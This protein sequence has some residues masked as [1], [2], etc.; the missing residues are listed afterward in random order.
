MLQELLKALRQELEDVQQDSPSHLQKSQILL[1]QADAAVTLGALLHKLEGCNE[2]TD[3]MLKSELLMVGAYR[4][5]IQK[6]VAKAELGTQRKRTEV[7]VDAMHRF[8]EHAIPDMDQ[9]QKAG[10]KRVCFNL[11]CKL[12]ETCICYQ[13]YE[14]FSAGLCVSTRIHAGSR[15]SYRGS[16]WKSK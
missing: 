6:V 5:K 13:A 11:D 2:L 1:C 3:V 9:R 10:L 8:I 4:E 14:Y 15:E 12:M 16:R 7:N